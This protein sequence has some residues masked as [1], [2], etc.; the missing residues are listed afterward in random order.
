MTLEALT[1]PGVDPGVWQV[2]NRRDR[3]AIAPTDRPGA[4][5]LYAGWHVD[6]DWVADRRRPTIVRLRR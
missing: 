5:F 1:L 6:P 3:A 4:C 2:R